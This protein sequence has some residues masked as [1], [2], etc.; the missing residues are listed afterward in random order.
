M[1]RKRLTWNIVQENLLETIDLFEDPVY[2]SYIEKEL[3]VEIYNPVLNELDGGDPF[4]YFC[5]YF[6]PSAVNNSTYVF[7]DNQTKQEFY[8]M[9]LEYGVVLNIKEIQEG[10]SKTEK[11]TRIKLASKQEQKNKTCPET[12]AKKKSE[13][14][15]KSLDKLQ[16]RMANET[17]PRIRTN[18]QRK[19]QKILEH[20][21]KTV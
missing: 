6:E 10:E 8:E 16:R 14:M 1:M 13:Q 2:G 12:I 17:N 7:K 20:M 11:Q 18:I 15:L 21:D 9:A 5:S 3:F 19:M 4:Y